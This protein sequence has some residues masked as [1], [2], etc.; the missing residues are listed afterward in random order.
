MGGGGREKVGDGE[1]RMMVIHEEGK[2]EK[3]EGLFVM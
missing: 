2:R 3:M 1:L